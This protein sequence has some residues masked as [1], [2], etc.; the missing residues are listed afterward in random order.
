M[1]LGCLLC[2]EVTKGEKSMLK[3]LQKF[4]AENIEFQYNIVE[5]FS[6]EE[7]S[8]YWKKL[9]VP[10]LQSNENKAIKPEGQ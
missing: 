1:Q 6:C 4:H 2:H 8:G 9:I 5:N 7:G 3:H 10:T